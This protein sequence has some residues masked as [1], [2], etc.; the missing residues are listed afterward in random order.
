MKWYEI[1]VSRPFGRIGHALFADGNRLF[2]VGGSPGH[3]KRT[4]DFLREIEVAK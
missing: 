2:A 4:K 1:P 3:G